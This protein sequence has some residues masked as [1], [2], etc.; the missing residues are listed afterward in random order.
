MSWLLAPDCSATAVRDPLVETANPWTSPAATFAAPMPII[1][2][3]GSTSSPRRAAKADEVAIVSVS[4]TS[5]MPTAAM[6]SGPTSESC[7][8]GSDG[9]GKPCGSEPTVAI[10][11]ARPSTADTTVAPTTATSTAGTFFVRSA[12]DRAAR[13][14]RRRRSRA[15]RLRSGRG[16]STNSRDLVDEAVGVGGEAEQLRQ[17]ADDDRDR[18]PVHV[19]DLHLAGQQVGDEAELADPEADLDERRRS[20]RASRRA[21]SPFPGSSVAASG[22]IAAK[23]SG[24]TDESG[25]STSTRDGPKIGVAD[26]AADRRVEAGDRGQTGELRVGHALRD[27]D[28]GEHEPGDHV[29]AQPRPLVRAGSPNGR[30]PTFQRCRVLAHQPSPPPVV[31][32][33]IRSCSRQ[34]ARRTFRELLHVMGSAAAPLRCSGEV[35]AEAGGF[36]AFAP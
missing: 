30:D 17:L 3:F 21:R 34:A 32:P 27:E 2:W 10:S 24:E 36:P 8:H 26:E 22:T 20:R 18:Q 12:A 16:L 14:A 6:S 33:E 11:S 23:I 29:G 7:V 35:L 9:V 13:R 19:A 4:D 28:R 15:R 1:S 25:P 5:V 31:A